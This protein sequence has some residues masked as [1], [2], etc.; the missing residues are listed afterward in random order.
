MLFC[1]VQQAVRTPEQMDDKKHSLTSHSRQTTMGTTNSHEPAVDDTA[2]TSLE[3]PANNAVDDD[4]TTMATTNNQEPAGATSANH[5][6]PT[7]TAA[8]DD[9]TKQLYAYNKLRAQRKASN[10]RC[11]L[12]KQ[13]EKKAAKESIHP[14]KV[15]KM[16]RVIEDQEGKDVLTRFVMTVAFGKRRPLKKFDPSKWKDKLDARLIYDRIE[17]YQTTKNEHGVL[18]KGNM[19]P[20]NSTTIISLMNSDGRF[21]DGLQM[22]DLFEVKKS[23]LTNAN[24]G[25]FAKKNFKAGDIIGLFYGKVQNKASDSN[26][27]MEGGKHKIFIGAQG[28][29]ESGKPLYFGLHIANDPIIYEKS[30]RMATRQ[31]SIVQ[32]H[33]FFIDEDFIARACRDINIGDELFLYYQWPTDYDTGTECTC[34]GCEYKKSKYEYQLEIPFDQNH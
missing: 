1:V 14:R 31:D 34:E 20:G 4:T 21:K 33:N 19:R 25:L 7:S 30:R 6:S 16:K 17:R 13:Q 12:K 24:M 26:Y 23:Q 27:E 11:R 3:S 22:I 2:N 9:T 28:G 15:W 32:A 18:V 8:D 10:D 29:L 5:K